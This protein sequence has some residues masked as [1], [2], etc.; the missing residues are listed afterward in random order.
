MFFLWENENV[1]LSKTVCYDTILKMIA[2]SVTLISAGMWCYC[3]ELPP[4][5]LLFHLC[6]KKRTEKT[7][8]QKNISPHA[9]RTRVTI[10]QHLMINYN[11]LHR[12]LS[13]VTVV[14]D[15]VVVVVL[16]L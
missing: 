7:N 4:S 11:A 10:F 5:F 16:V 12:S 1:H 14:V 8:K 2:A 15:V 6:R 9:Y 3:V 13:R